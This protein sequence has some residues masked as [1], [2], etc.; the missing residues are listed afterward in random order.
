MVKMLTSG[1]LI[2]EIEPGIVTGVGSV[3]ENF[4]VKMKKVNKRNATSHMAVMS[5][6]VLFRAILTFGIFINF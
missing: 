5:M 1:I 3:S 4:A 2:S 6:C